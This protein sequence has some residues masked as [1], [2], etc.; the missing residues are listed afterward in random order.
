MIPALEHKRFRS[1]DGTEIAYQVR[2]PAGAPAIVMSNGLGGTCEAY[3]HIYAALGHG[4]RIVSWDYRGLYGSARPKDLATLAVPHQARDLDR[5]LGV[6]DIGRAV[7]VGW[8]MGVQ[9]NFEYFKLRPEKFAGIAAINGTYGLPFNSALASRLTRYVIPAALSM[10]QKQ[11]KTISRLTARSVAWSGLLPTLQRLGMVSPT[12]DAE[13]FIDL[14]KGF[15]TMDFDCYAR[16][17]RALGAHDAREVLSRIE[18]P[19]AVITGDKDLLTPVFTA[20]KMTAAIKGARLTVIPGGTH[21]TPVEYPAVVIA[22]I[23]E[24][25]AR[26]PSHAELAQPARAASG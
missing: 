3:R 16:T 20:E 18:V 1:Y 12:C 9:I 21:Y 15:A 4:F 24:L 25:L 11:H 7:F 2:G 13:T 17:L 5:L 10:M 23:R 6:E 26:V 8:S 14:S 19:T 22:A